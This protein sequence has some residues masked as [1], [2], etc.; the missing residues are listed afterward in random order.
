VGAVTTVTATTATGAADSAPLATAVTGGGLATAGF[1]LGALLAPLIAH[2]LGIPS[3]GDDLYCWVEYGNS[4]WLSPAD[5]K[6]SNDALQ[7]QLHPD[8]T[9]PT[10]VTPSDTSPQKPKP[11]EGG[12]PQPTIGLGLRDDLWRNDI[13][14]AITY[15]DWHKAGLTATPYRE[16]T[17]S[18]GRFFRVFDEVTG[19]AASIR[20]DVTN[21]VH[22][23]NPYGWTQQELNT[24][25]TPSRGLLGN[26]TFCERDKEVIWNG[27]GFSPKK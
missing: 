10:P 5:A 15:F 13:Y 1:T 17:A 27:S 12:L 21:F 26:T 23:E 6:R 24:V 19:K 20:F 16:M 8:Q 2:Q 11:C 18:R 9:N 25:L 22:N 14:G 7:A 4:T 3:C